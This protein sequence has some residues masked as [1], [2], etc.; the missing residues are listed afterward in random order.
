MKSSP[1]ESLDSEVCQAVYGVFVGPFAPDQNANNLSSDLKSA[2]RS[3]PK[4]GNGNEHFNIVSSW[5]KCQYY[6]YFARYR[7][8]QEKPSHCFRNL[9]CFSLWSCK[10]FLHQAHILIYSANI[11]SIVRISNFHLWVSKC[12]NFSDFKIVRIPDFTTH[13]TQWRAKFKQTLEIIWKNDVFE[14]IWLAW[15]LSHKTQFCEIIWIFLKKCLKRDFGNPESLKISSILTLLDVECKESLTNFRNFLKLEDFFKIYIK[16]IQVILVHFCTFWA[17]FP[18][19]LWIIPL[20]GFLHSVFQQNCSQLS[21]KKSTYFL[22]WPLLQ[23]WIIECHASKLCGTCPWNSILNN[24]KRCESVVL[25][26][27]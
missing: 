27:C 25:K 17:V 16:I 22:Q 14:Q 23:K 4:C 13:T 3:E 12:R 7:V 2:H 9:R 18:Q 24:L 6:S 8:I 26:K 21:L 10:N 5:V 19:N 1:L 20:Y 15:N 11:N